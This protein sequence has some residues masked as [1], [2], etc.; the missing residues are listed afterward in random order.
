MKPGKT[1][2]LP[3][4]VYSGT[5]HNIVLEGCTTLQVLQAVKSVMR[6]QMFDWLHAEPRVNVNV[7]RT[8]NHR[9]QPSQTFLGSETNKAWT[10]FQQLTAVWNYDQQIVAETCSSSEQEIHCIPNLEMEISL[11]ENQQVQKKYKSIPR[12]LYPEVKQYIK[13]LRNQ[14]FLTELRSPYTSTVICVQKKDGSFRLCTDYQELNHKTIADQHLL[15]TV[16]ET[17]D[18]LG[19]NSWFRVLDQGK[20]YHQEFIIKES[21]VATVFIMPGG[22]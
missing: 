7:S 22:V 12:P 11:K 20:V 17:S 5:D 14:N 1:S 16:Q 3:I 13:D 2:R 4:A 18:S 10:P 6:E 19:G 9:N 8:M 21:R 15:L